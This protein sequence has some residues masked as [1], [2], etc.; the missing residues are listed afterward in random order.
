ME[1]SNKNLTTIIN[2]ETAINS[3]AVPWA[4][5]ASNNFYCGMLHTKGSNMLV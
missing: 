4:S 1:I 5:V 3:S 2:K